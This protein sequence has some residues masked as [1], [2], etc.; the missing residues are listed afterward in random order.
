MLRSVGL[1]L[2]TG[3]ADDDCAAVGTYAEAG[4]RFG[5][6]ILWMAPLALPMMIAVV[7]LSGKLGLV[8]G[9]GLFSVLR[10]RSPRWLLFIVLVGVIIG[11]IIEAGVDIG[12]MAAALGLLVPLPRWA[13]LVVVTAAALAF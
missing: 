7:Y 4:A 1:G 10:R 8:T 6:N 13:I 2:I 5:Y 3:A 11:N 12:G 9:Q